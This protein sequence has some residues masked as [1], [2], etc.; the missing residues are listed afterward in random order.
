MI[1]AGDIGGTKT[2][3]AYVDMNGDRLTLQVTE[4]YSSRDHTSFSELVRRFIRDH[5]AVIG[6][7]SFGVAGPVVNGRCEA[8]NLPWVLDEGEISAVLNGAPAR[9]LNDL[10]ATAYGILRLGANDRYV[11]NTGMPEDHGTIGVIAAGTGLGEGVLVWDGSGY[12]ALPTEGG[13][14]DFAP[15]NEV[16]ME[17][18]RFLLK[19]HERVSY[20]RVVSGPGLYSLYQFFRERSGS[21][22]PGW[23][24]QQLAVDDSSVVVSRAA[25]EG[26]DNVCVQALDSFV[27]LYGAEAG[28]LALK[29]LARGGI[30]VAGGIAPKILDAITR[31]AF[32][33]S[34]MTKGRFSHLLG[35]I[36]VIV[37]LNEKTA[38]LGAA[39]YALM[40]GSHD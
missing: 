4:S 36:P 24:K 31:G 15:R 34:F 8:T 11:L 21:P 27:S 16:E 19:R 22:E 28:N 25:M 38:L 37:V 6:G 33:K 40:K 9:L 30:Y 20:E 2:N 23:L 13:H 1:L 18:L 3:L 7:G 32:L 26:K 12:K 14:V 39:H 17:L 29:I 35:T 5:P 10:E